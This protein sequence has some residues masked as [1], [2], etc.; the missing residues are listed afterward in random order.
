MNYETGR[1]TFKQANEFCKLFDTRVGTERDLNNIDIDTFYVHCF[2]I[3]TAVEI[4]ICIEL[5]TAVL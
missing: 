5:E 3:E 4:N 2:E 1:L